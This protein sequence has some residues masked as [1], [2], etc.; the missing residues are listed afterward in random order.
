MTVIRT[1]QQRR[2]TAGAWAT[3][4]PVLAAGEIGWETD[5]RRSKLG[6]GAT[7][8]NAL[9]YTSASSDV[10]RDFNVTDYGWITPTV[11]IPEPDNTS[12]LQAA[13]NAASAW[14]FLNDPGKDFY[15]GGIKAPVA[16]ATR[17]YWPASSMTGVP[18]RGIGTDWVT[19]AAEQDVLVKDCDNPTLNGIWTIKTGAWVRR[20]DADVSADFFMALTNV[21]VLDGYLWKGTTWRLIGGYGVPT[22]GTTPLSWDGKPLKAKGIVVGNGSPIFVSSQIEVKEGVS[23]ALTGPIVGAVGA[24]T[25][26]HIIAFRMHSDTRTP[27][28]L[29]CEYTHGGALLAHR[30]TDQR[31]DFAPISA[32][33]VGARGTGARNPDAAPGAADCPITGFAAYGFPYNLA[34]VWTLSGD[35]GHR[36]WCADMDARAMYSLAAGDGAWLRLGNSHFELNIDSAGNTALRMDYCAQLNA[37]LIVNA[38]SAASDVVIFGGQLTEAVGTWAASRRLN[39][40]IQLNDPTGGGYTRGLNIGNMLGVNH[41]KLAA[42]NGTTAVRW[43]AGVSNEVVIDADLTTGTIPFD[44][45]AGVTAGGVMMVRQNGRVRNIE[46]ASR[47]SGDRGNANVTLTAN[48]V[49][50]QQ[51]ATT[52][53]AN[54]TVTLP[55]TGLYPGLTF[56]VLRTGLGAFTL[57]VGSAKTIPASTA[58]RVDVEYTGSAWVLTGYG[59]L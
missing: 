29:S 15:D 24:S 44:F 2:D 16:W 57:A 17:D 35:L 59:T 43:S 5:T 53:T 50:V 14:A 40:D 21:R 39:L 3:V 54:R 22:L 1:I 9:A 37:K 41:I 52:L 30:C 25:M 46:A 31:A 19:P 47:F 10:T 11:P 56:T 7:A 32:F 51:F 23:L 55:T 6:N 45:A 27:L 18:A 36:L 58:A 12:A 38:P 20:A 4:N 33:Y 48:E 13:I 28:L 8:W 42:I 26:E 34:G 49:P